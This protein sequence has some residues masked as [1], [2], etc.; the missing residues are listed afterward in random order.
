[1]TTI[2]LYA[3]CLYSKWGFS[4]G[5]ILQDAVAVL[6]LNV[7]HKDVLCQLV[8]DKLLPVLPYPVKTERISTAHNPIR[9]ADEHHEDPSHA[10]NVG[11]FVDVTYDDIRRCA[12]DLKA[13]RADEKNVRF[14]ERYSMT[15]HTT[16]FNPAL[17][18][19]YKPNRLGQAVVDMDFAALEQRITGHLAG[20]YMLNGG[21]VPYWIRTASGNARQRRR[22]VRLW[23][24]QGF[25]VTHWSKA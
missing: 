19:P 1:M 20:K 6:G 2:T 17:A 18:A 25:T 9:V 24:R 8:E 22:Q 10:F 23:R 21:G 13:R 11:T 15:G 12:E 3:Q 4:D 7:Y 14:V 16:S 5:D